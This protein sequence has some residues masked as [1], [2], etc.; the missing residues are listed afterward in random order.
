MSPNRRRKAEHTEEWQWLLPLFEWPEQE[1]Y[2]LIR[3][4]VLFGDS[5]AERAV[6]TSSSERTLYRKISGFENEGMLSLFG[7]EPAKRQV[8]PL[9]IRRMI[10]DLKAEYP[11]L[12]ANEISRICYARSARRPASGRFTPGRWSVWIAWRLWSFASEPRSSTRT[13]PRAAGCIFA[14]RLSGGANGGTAADHHSPALPT[15]GGG[16]STEGKGEIKYRARSHRRSWRGR[17]PLGPDAF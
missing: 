6:E 9:S 1:E 12:N 14:A 16:T 17:D 2:E 10:L 5:V 13:I 8:L 7:T 3:P 15:G 4:L 11:P